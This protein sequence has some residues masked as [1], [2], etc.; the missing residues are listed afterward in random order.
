[1]SI[2]ANWLTA[3]QCAT[4]AVREQPDL[5]IAS[6]RELQ[7]EYERAVD[8]V[9]TPGTGLNRRPPRISF[10]DVCEGLGVHADRLRER[11]QEQIRN[12]APETELSQAVQ[13]NK[14]IVS[15]ETM[16]RLHTEPEFVEKHAL[17]ASRTMTRLRSNPAF[18]AK[19]VAGASRAMTRNWENPEFVA[20]NSERTKQRWAE[21]RA[22]KAQQLN[23]DAECAAQLTA[24]APPVAEPDAKVKPS[25]GYK[26]K[27]ALPSPALSSSRPR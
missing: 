16:T 20:A 5:V 18:V 4:V 12:R 21:H 22:R 10:D 27:L 23:P 13:L 3:T 9:N 19:Q 26:Y 14:S 11:L 1:M 15:R 8:W 2:I 7:R 24:R 17:T 25:T 6:A